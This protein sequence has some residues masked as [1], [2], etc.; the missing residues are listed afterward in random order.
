MPTDTFW[1]V[2]GPDWGTRSTV[3]R[4]R[5]GCIII[6]ATLT[7]N[8]ALAPLN[9][10]DNTAQNPEFRGSCTLA[11]CGAGNRSTLAPFPIDLP[12]HFDINILIIVLF[13]SSKTA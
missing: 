1:G 4:G 9:D 2:P 7:M 5:C 11:S 3:T 13:V 12:R 6:Q 10:G 8:E